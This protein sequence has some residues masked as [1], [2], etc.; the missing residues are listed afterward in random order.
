[1]FPEFLDGQIHVGHYVVRRPTG[2]IVQGVFP[3]C[4]RDAPSKII[5]TAS[6]AS[7]FPDRFAVTIYDIATS[8]FIAQVNRTDAPGGWG[9]SS[10]TLQWRAFYGKFQFVFSRN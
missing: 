2:K 4:L 10:V 5:A 3:A 9:Q 1:L 8:G 6:G 7:Y